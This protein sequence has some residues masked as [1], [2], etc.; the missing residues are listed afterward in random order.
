M[1][2]TGSLERRK[3]I[4][5]LIHVTR[6]FRARHNNCN[7]QQYA[8]SS[9]GRRQQINKLGDETNEHEVKQAIMKLINRKS[10]GYD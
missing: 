7:V 9:E 5:T 8:N 3:Q 1:H 2:H 10:V 4:E 6:E